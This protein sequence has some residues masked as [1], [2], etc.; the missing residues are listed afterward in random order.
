MKMVLYTKYI[1][2]KIPVKEEKSKSYV[3]SRS[4]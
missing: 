2:Q 4:I 3:T 1:Y